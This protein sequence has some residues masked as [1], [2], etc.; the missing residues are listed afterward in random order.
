MLLLFSTIVI[1]LSMGAFLF[2]AFSNLFDII[3]SDG[4][5]NSYYG[6]MIGKE[7]I[8]IFR[9]LGVFIMLYII[10]LAAVCITYTHRVIEPLKPI[11]RQLD[12]MNAGDYSQR[13]KSTEYDLPMA[14]A[15][16]DKLNQLTEKLEAAKDRPAAS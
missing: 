1:T 7:L 8:N 2:L 6:Q 16:V 13:I 5:A 12:A 14:K 15:Q 11:I 3:D 9:Y 4:N 10:F